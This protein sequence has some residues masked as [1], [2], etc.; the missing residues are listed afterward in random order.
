[1]GTHGVENR[2]RVGLGKAENLEEGVPFIDIDCV[3]IT[4]LIVV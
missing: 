3:T 4:I 2:S 1:M